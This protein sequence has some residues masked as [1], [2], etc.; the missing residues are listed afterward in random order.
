MSKTPIEIAAEAVNKQI[1]SI[2]PGATGVDIATQLATSALESIKASG[3]E[4]A[5]DEHTPETDEWGAHLGNCQCGKE[6]D[7]FNAH[8]ADAILA[9]LLAEGGES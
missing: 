5:L 4:S 9:H 8:L 1:R 7:D 3:I 6:V 2:F